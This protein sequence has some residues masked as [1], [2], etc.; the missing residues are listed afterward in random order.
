MPIAVP[1]KSAPHR[2]LTGSD[3]F[4]AQGAG[5]QVQSQPYRADGGD[6]EEPPQSDVVVVVE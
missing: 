5:E 2:L 3:S 1:K 6:N 4:R